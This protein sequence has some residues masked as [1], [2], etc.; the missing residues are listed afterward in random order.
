MWVHESFL[1][2]LIVQNIANIQ[3]YAWFLGVKLISNAGGINP[4][5]CAEALRKICAAEDVKLKIAVVK[6]DDL[7]PQVQK[8]LPICC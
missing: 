5:G 3:Q 4:S 6:G 7:M 1:F 8:L 2:F